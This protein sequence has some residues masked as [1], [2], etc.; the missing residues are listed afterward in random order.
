MWL[1]RADQKQRKARVRWRPVQVAAN[2]GLEWAATSGPVLGTTGA[3][4]ERANT[5][6]TGV[7]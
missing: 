4:R 7:K 1:L 5:T 3:M 2:Y 6:A